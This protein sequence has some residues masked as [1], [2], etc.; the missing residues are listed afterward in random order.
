[1]PLLKKPGAPRLLSGVSSTPSQTAS[2]GPSSEEGGTKSQ[3]KDTTSKPK[4]WLVAIA[5][6]ENSNGCG[7]GPSDNVFE[8]SIS[9]TSE[10]SLSLT[11]ESR[12]TSQGWLL[13]RAENIPFSE[14]LRFEFSTQL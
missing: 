9:T 14:I 7:D 5:K 10:S 3:D 11:Q 6:D 4:G 13:A 1:M 8:E 2:Q 12:R